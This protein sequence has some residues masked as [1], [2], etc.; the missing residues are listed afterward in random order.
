MLRQS[1][2]WLMRCAAAL[3]AVLMLFTLLLGIWARLWLGDHLDSFRPRIEAAVSEKAQIQAH[4]GKLDVI[5]HGL[6]PEF[7]LKNL[8]LK[9]ASGLV[10]LSLEQVNV[11]LALLPLFEGNIDFAAL[12]ID[13][14]KLNIQRRPDGRFVL[15]GILL[16]LGSDEP[17]IPFLDWLLNQ[18]ELSIHDGLVNWEDQKLASPLARF[19][20][21]ELH[22]QGAGNR[23]RFKFSF[24]APADIMRTPEFYGDFYG[25]DTQ[26]FSEWSGTFGASADFIDLARVR[27][28]I[29]LPESLQSRM[30]QLAPRGVIQALKIRWNHGDS[31]KSD[32]TIQAKLTDVSVLAYQKIPGLEHVSGSVQ[33]DQS[34]GRVDIEGQNFVMTMNAYFDH[35]LA[36][37]HIQSSVHWENEAAASVITIEQCRIEDPALAGHVEGTLRIDQQGHRMAH[38]RAALERAEVKAVG[39]FLPNDIGPDARSW[40]KTSLLSGQA[41]LATMELDGDLKAFP[42][43]SKQAGTFKVHVPV[44]DVR[45]DYANGWPALTGIRGELEFD[46]VGLTIHGNEATQGSL[47]AREVFGKIAD[48]DADHPLLDIEAKVRGPVQAGFDFIAA[49]PLKKSIGALP[50][51]FKATGG[52][53]VALKIHVPLDKTD[54]TSVIGSVAVDGAELKNDSGDIPPITAL[55]GR[56][57]FTQDKVSADNLTAKILGG[58]VHGNIASRPAEVVVEAGGQFD[59]AEVNHFYV[60]DKLAFLKG[61]GE[62]KGLFRVV[63]GTT[64]ID[65]RAKTPLF[66]QVSD[67]E[68]HKHG[69]DPLTMDG[70]GKP[71]LRA[72]LQEFV[73]AL[74]PAAEGSLDWKVNYKKSSSGD[75]LSGTGRFALLGK[76]GELT[77]SGHPDAI[78]L[79]LSGG[80][81]A[82]ALER[83]VPRLPKGLMTGASTWQANVDERPGQVFFKL[84]SDLKGLAI[85][86]PA[87]FGK[88]ASDVLALNARINRS[89]QRSPLILTGRLDAQLSFSALLP[90]GD[91]DDLKRIAIKI[92][93]TEAP[94]VPATNGVQITGELASFDADAWKKALRVHPLPASSAETAAAGDLPIHFDLNIQKASVGRY[95]LGAHHV[96]GQYSALGLKLETRGPNVD[97][98][99]DWSNEGPGHLS[100]KLDQLILKSDPLVGT[101]KPL[102][103]DPSDDPRQLPIVDLAAAKVE[104]D[105]RVIGRV[106]LHGEPDAGGWKISKLNL[107]QAH[108]SLQAQ[109]NWTLRAGQTRTSMSGEIKAQDTG[110]LLQDLGYSKALARG[111]TSLRAQLDW[112]G[113]PGDFVVAN[114]NGGMDLDCQ[115][116]QFLTVEPGVGRLIGLLSLQSLPRRITLDFRDI[117]SE[118]FAFDSLA[119]HIEVKQGVLSTKNLE[120][121]GPAANIALTGKASVITETADLDVKVSPAVGNG[122]SLA[123]T[124]VGGPVVGAATYLIQRLLSNPID[125]LLTYHYEVTGPWEDPQVNRVGLDKITGSKSKNDK[126]P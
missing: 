94:P 11:R 98:V 19:P 68:V 72:V 69:S 86:L 48:L 6:L 123:S 97:G 92:A 56:V 122:V 66:G 46:G 47:M 110:L 83:I 59:N 116:G 28:L 33:A 109:G 106:D 124:V 77:L 62:W 16:P 38:L 101:A 29:P 14:P 27:H 108:G 20:Q 34:G 99:M 104:V 121:K 115:S 9:D 60:D 105:Q 70:H 22:L 126:K 25:R 91:K 100:A 2:I 13:R 119:G 44:E 35:P 7:V 10:D 125:Q 90:E 118:G 93:N 107:T 50:K 103:A 87:P 8:E 4:I 42:F 49:S 17:G 85:E 64:D 54:D 52:A 51:L 117:F 112:P 76:P 71:A 113:D 75:H 23:H 57:Q 89:A 12:E 15:A 102:V 45:L 67:V 58:I 114:L 41:H 24:T 96:M 120:M 82:T 30:D 95:R 80:M 61:R 31:P 3:T 32:Y 73:P 53:D 74:M 88:S 78:V 37:H 81:D 5:W 63:E 55:K 39:H 65:I 111:K 26:H 79:D 43:A 1:S 84:N 21:F 40:I 36:L 18:N